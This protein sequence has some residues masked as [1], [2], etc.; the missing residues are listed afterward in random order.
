M[1]TPLP[2]SISNPDQK[3]R[4]K[5]VSLQT[6]VTFQSSSEV[7][8]IRFEDY[9][10]LDVLGER[11]EAIAVQLKELLSSVTEAV[12]EA[13]ESEGELSVEI[14][15]AL[16]LKASAGIQY[17]FFNVGAG[18]SKTN[19]MKVTLKTKVTPKDANS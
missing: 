4:R 16:E 12:R 9:E 15:G 10:I 2:E 14:N 5:L 6:L 18:A 19:T 13:I 3:V 17:L 11:E 1:V 7:S 8:K